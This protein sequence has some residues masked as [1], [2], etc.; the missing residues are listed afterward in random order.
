MGLLSPA[1]LEVLY[2]LKT[3]LGGR[4]DGKCLSRLKTLTLR[5]RAIAQA[6]RTHESWVSLVPP[7]NPTLEAG[8][9]D[10]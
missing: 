2:S 3:N 10:P 9:W 8:M 6:S 4:G 5:V 7:R 1:A